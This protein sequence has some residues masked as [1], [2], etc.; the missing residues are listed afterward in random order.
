MLQAM[1]TGHGGCLSTCHANGPADALHRIETMAL[2]GGD[3]VPLGAVRSQMVRAVDLVVHV[4]RTAG[5]ARRVAAV[6]EVGGDRDDDRD[7]AIEVRTLADGNRV[8][9]DGRRPARRE[10]A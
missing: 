8:A 9:A 3:D 5:A 1:N 7:G 2:L 4:V 10:A 6:A